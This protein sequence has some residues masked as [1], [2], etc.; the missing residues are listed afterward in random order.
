VSDRT[1]SAKLEQ[2]RLE[3]VQAAGLT[4]RD[5]Q[6]WRRGSIQHKAKRVGK[7]LAEKGLL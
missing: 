1:K 5:L 6:L 2:Q 7:L 4:E 3:A